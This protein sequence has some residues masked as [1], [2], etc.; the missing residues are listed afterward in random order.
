MRSC[1]KVIPCAPARSGSAMPGGMLSSRARRGL[2]IIP[3]GTPQPAFHAA[4]GP[5]E[6]IR[7]RHDRIPQAARVG[8]CASWA[9]RRCV[10]PRTPSLWRSRA[11]GHRPLHSRVSAELQRVFGRHRL[12]A[13]RAAQSVGLAAGRRTRELE[14]RRPI[15]I[16]APFN[17]DHLQMV[18]AERLIATVTGRYRYLAAVS[19]MAKHATT[20]GW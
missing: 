1:H 5:E 17:G 18:R 14:T 10:G 6:A 2:S 9:V 8:V 12:R 19:G 15:A 3:P 11:Q 13:A 20:R 7:G 16:F 4:L